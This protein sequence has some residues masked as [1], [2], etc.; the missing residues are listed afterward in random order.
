M[1]AVILSA[2]SLSEGL[3]VGLVR[4]IS[5]GI[6][7]SPGRVTVAALGSLSHILKSLS[8]LVPWVPAPT[9]GPLGECL[10]RRNQYN[11]HQGSES[12]DRV[13]WGRCPPAASKGTVDG[14]QRWS[15]EIKG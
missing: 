12:P 11:D 15:L 13:R 2:L 6:P 5:S 3:V 4:A 9:P 1:C 8:P 14:D 7:G 10:G